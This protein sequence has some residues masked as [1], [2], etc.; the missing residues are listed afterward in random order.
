MMNVG[1]PEQAFELSFL[2]NDGV[3]LAREEFIVNEYIKIHPLALLKFKELT[4]ESAKD[5]IE[6]LTQGFKDKREF[7]VD[8]LAMGVG[9]IAAAFYPKDVILRFSDFKSNEYA[10][11]IGGKQFEP[12]EENPM[13]GWRGASRYYHPSYVEAFGLECEA[14]KKVRDEFGLANL[15]VMVPMCRTPAEG[16]KVLA[17]MKKFGLPK[18]KNGLEVYVMC[19]LPSNVVLA[20]EFCKIFD[21]F[22][23]GSNDLTQMTLGVDR[24]SALVAPIYDERSGAVRNL[25]EHVIAVAKRYKKKIGI[26]GDAPST[27]PEFAKFL[28]DEGIDSISLSPDALVQMRAKI[29]EFER[30]RRR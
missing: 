21:G 30:H 29:A 14:I 27:Y 7:F 11:L 1:N 6:K 19:E 9:M 5:Q 15:K 23:I 26:C 4:D 18:H 22:S 8:K 24:D 3:G 20:E 10:N 28:V 25:I 17:M 13:L 16:E 2:P 12:D